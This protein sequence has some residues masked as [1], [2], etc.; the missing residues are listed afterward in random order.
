MKTHPLL[1][2]IHVQPRQPIPRAGLLRAGKDSMQRVP[3]GTALWF[4][5]FSPALWSSLCRL[6]PISDLDWEV[7][8]EAGPHPATH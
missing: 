6:S 5:C 2:A 8:W 3:W 7:T 4:S 1:V